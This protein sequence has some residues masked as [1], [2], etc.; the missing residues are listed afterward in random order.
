MML[1]AEGFD[2]YGDDETEMTD[3]AWAQ[4]NNVTLTTDQARTGTHSLA[5]DSA[6]S[7]A[8]RVFGGPKTTVGL[9]AAFYQL[10]LP[11]LNQNA[12]FFCFHDSANQPQVTIALDTTGVFSAWRGNG[13]GAFGTLLGTSSTLMATASWNHLEARV[14]F[15]G[16]AGTVEL[17]LNGV[18]ILN[19]VGQNT[20]NGTAPA[21]GESSASQAV[22]KNFGSS[23]GTRYMDDLVCWDDTGAQNND[24]IGDRKVFTD[25]PDA[26]TADADWAPSAGATRF[27][28]IDEIPADGDATYDTT[29]NAGDRMGVTFPDLPAEI[30][31]ISAVLFLHKTRKTDAGDC[32][33][34]VHCDSGGD[35]ADGTDRPMTTQYAYYQDV[36]EVDPHTAAPF[37]NAAA[38]AVAMVVERTL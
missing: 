15:D 10:A 19:L 11:A 30:V 8:R 29:T 12:G 27:A 35:E 4:L 3:G 20:V 21:A 32:N 13:G 6:G 17:R 1:W 22:F 9:S 37:T 34:T 2:H 38:S 36:F 14:T 26:D 5:L 18:T 28:M 31:A 33:I 25:M 7:L 16:A 23:H 24:F